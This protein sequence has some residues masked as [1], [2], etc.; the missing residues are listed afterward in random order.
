MANPVGNELIAAIGSTQYSGAAATTEYFT[1]AQLAGSQFYNVAKITSGTSYTAQSTDALIALN[2]STLSAK[3]IT[4]PSAS[5][6]GKSYTIKDEYG[7]AGA[8]NITIAP[9]SGTIDNSSSFVISQNYGSI[10]LIAD[11]STNWMVV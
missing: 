9:T 8:Y 7:N 2:S 6:S 4:I 10:T 3:S 5:V 1:V 11:G